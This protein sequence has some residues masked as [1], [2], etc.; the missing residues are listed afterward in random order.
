M[1]EERDNTAVQIH[2][3]QEKIIELENAAGTRHEIHTLYALFT[4]NTILNVLLRTKRTEL[5][6]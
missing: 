1:S 6:V 3:L 4:L 5:L 2:E